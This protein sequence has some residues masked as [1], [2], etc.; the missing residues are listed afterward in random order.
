MICFCIAAGLASKFS[1]SAFSVRKLFNSCS[2]LMPSS[3]ANWRRRIS[4]ISSAWRSDKLNASISADFGSSECRMMRITSSIFNKT[5]KRPS[6]IWIRSS[7]WPSRCW[8]RRVTVTKRNLIH[9]AIKSFSVFWPGRPSKPIVTILMDKLLSSEV[10]ASKR[11]IK[12]SEFCREDFGSNT[13]RTALSLPDSSRT[14]SSTLR[15][16]CLVCI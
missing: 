3:R 4:R 1:S 12:S 16:N 13:K 11:F 5:S 15:I 10:C 2:I 9:S 14:R 8:Q 7:T 6:K